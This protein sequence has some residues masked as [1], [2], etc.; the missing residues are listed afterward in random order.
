MIAATAQCAADAA[1]VARNCRWDEDGGVNRTPWRAMVDEVLRGNPRLPATT[2][3]ALSVLIDIDAEVEKR[4]APYPQSLAYLTA[5]C[6]QADPTLADLETPPP[7]ER[8]VG[9][10]LQAFADDGQ[11]DWSALG[12]VAAGWLAALVG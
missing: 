8:T 9:H 2:R 3:A 1:T 6:Q 12:R 5:M 10:L 11:A 4:G 7:G